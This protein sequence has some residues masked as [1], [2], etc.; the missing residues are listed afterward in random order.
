VSI[1]AVQTRGGGTV[2]AES[3]SRPLFKEAKVCF[4]FLF[5]NIFFDP[6]IEAGVLFP[7]YIPNFILEIH[8]SVK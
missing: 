7:S 3:I 2:A 5:G 4:G 8:D 6:T 1:S